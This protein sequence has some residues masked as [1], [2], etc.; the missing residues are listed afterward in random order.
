MI[1]LEAKVK[2]HQGPELLHSQT[3]HVSD[4]S[5][6]S[7]RDTSFI[8]LPSHEAHPVVLEATLACSGVSGKG[9]SVAPFSSSSPRLVVDREQCNSGPAVA[10]LATR[11][12]N[13]Y[14]CLK[15]KLGCS[16]RG[17][18][19]KRHLVRSRKSPPQKFF[20]V[21]SSVSGPQEFRASLQGPDCS[22]SK[23]HPRSLECD[24]G[25]TVQTQSGDPDRVV[26]FS[27]GVQSLVFEVDLFATRFNHKLPKFV[28]PV[29]DPTAWA[30]DAP[31]LPWE[32]LDAGFLQ[33]LCSTK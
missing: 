23:T 31:S 16:L 8:R 26:P 7:D 32:N 9:H 3:V 4:R 20:G 30:V 29:P 10:P 19:G 14:R 21:K 13:G 22:D 18:H 11:S 1:Y 6:H 2:I 5:P 33:S 15:R 28:S 24:S 17:L 25:Q 27:A 12:A